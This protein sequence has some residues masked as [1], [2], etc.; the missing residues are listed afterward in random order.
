MAS[1]TS[2]AA[3][4]ILTSSIF[5]VLGNGEHKQNQLCMGI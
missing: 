4:R 2:V 1:E 5:K 3:A